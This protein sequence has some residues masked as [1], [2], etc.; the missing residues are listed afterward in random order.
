[1]VKKKYKSK[2]QTLRLKYNIQKRVKSHRKKMAQFAKDHPHL[3][4]MKKSKKDPGIPNLFP[5]KQDLIEKAERHKEQMDDEKKA[6][7]KRRQALNKKTITE[8]AKA[9]ETAQKNREEKADYDANAVQNNK[10]SSRRRWYVKELRKVLETADVILEILDARDPIGCRCPNIEKMIQGKLSES[11][12]RPKKIILVLNKI[13]LVPA[14]TVADWIK[15]L[16]REFPTIA[17]KASTQTQGKIGQTDVKP[18]ATSSDQTAR[19]TCIGGAALLN[20][21][22]Q[23]SL[24]LN[25]KTAINVG[26][27]G[28]PNVG[29]SSIINSLKRSRAVGV[30]ANPGFTKSI[31]LVKLDKQ[32]NLLDSPGVLFSV[33]DD[34]SDLV[35]RNCLRVEEISDPTDGVNRILERCAHERLMQFYE[36]GAFTQLDEFL[37]QIA[38]KRCKLGKG[39]VPDMP[40]AARLVLKDW[41]QG[42]IPYFTSPPEIKKD[43]HASAAIVNTWGKTF[44]I[45]K[46]IEQSNQ[47]AVTALKSAK[48]AQKF[49]EMRSKP[50]MDLDVS[51]D[52]EDDDE[53]EDEDDQ[54]SDEELDVEDE[55]EEEGEDEDEAQDEE[56]EEEEQEMHVEAPAEEK[57]FVIAKG[58]KNNKSSSSNSGVRLDDPLNPQT[59]RKMKMDLKKQK[60]QQKKDNKR[61]GGDVNVEG[62]YDFEED[63]VEE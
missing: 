8:R 17:F 11:S 31:Q 5:F 23:Y 13:D 44:D 29:K 6:E 7:Q 9:F 48:K 42:K 15:Y 57:K 32:L 28:Y 33:R 1:M 36:I 35:L 45:D 2:R 61:G 52:P 49:V 43:E 51:V 62:T 24:N 12:Q 59:N 3:V 50:V 37:Y 20:L 25:L 53:D 16:R 63:W 10:D 27:I 56:E 46:L 30:G 18:S 60:K 14:E 39:G 34:E 21:L 47:E 54:Q 41:S 38:V 55:D 58:S 40:A 4:G 26:V 22:K 19:S